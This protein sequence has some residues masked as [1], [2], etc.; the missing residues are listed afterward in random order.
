MSHSRSVAVLIAIATVLAGCASGA[1]LSETEAA[2][3]PP[4]PGKTRIAVYRDGILGAAIQPE[5]TVDAEPTGRCQPNGV[6]FVD[7]SPGIHRL[8]AT[9][10]TTSA[11]LVDTSKYPMAYVRCSIGLGLMVGR[12][13]LTQVASETGAAAI[14]DLVLIGSYSLRK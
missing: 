11:I 10:E 6:F 9:T 14:N 13:N 5:I 8:T 7:V 4:A 3:M 12:P 1:K 2:A